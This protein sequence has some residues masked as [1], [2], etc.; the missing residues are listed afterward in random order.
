VYGLKK[1]YPNGFEALRD[2]SFGIEKK[3]IF[4]VV[5]PV[6]SGKSTIFNIIAGFIPN[7]GGAVKV[8]E[9]EIDM[10]LQY[11]FEDM[12]VC[13]QKNS[14]W[15]NLTVRQ[16]LNLFGNLKGLYG[17]TLSENMNFYLKTLQLEEVSNKKPKNLS[18]GN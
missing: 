12:G 8:K 6:G 4:G 5:G 3:Q 10:N 11:I 1:T 14:L 7:S 9:R 13:T 15:E 2:V 18:I 17:K 16:H